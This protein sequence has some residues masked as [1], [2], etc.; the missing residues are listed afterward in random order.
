MQ[1]QRAGSRGAV[2]WPDPVG[3]QPPGLTARAAFGP[4]LE[5]AGDHGGSVLAGCILSLRGRI[6]AQHFTGFVCLYFNQGKEI[7]WRGAVRGGY[8][9]GIVS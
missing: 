7:P 2:Q 1:Q 9:L 3:A 6:W 4:E 8:R 5:A